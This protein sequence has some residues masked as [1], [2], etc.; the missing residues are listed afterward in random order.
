MK[1]V[2]SRLA[3][4]DLVRLRAFI[5]SRNPDA[6]RGAALR[7]KQATQTLVEHPYIGR[8]VVPPDNGPIDDIREIP[9]AF[10]A[11]G[12]LLRYRIREEEVHILR[13]W[14]AREDRDD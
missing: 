14:Q 6:A 7:I 11:S 3:R 12:Y 5:G 13:I 1:V 8:S 2:F 9:I 4:R 10:G